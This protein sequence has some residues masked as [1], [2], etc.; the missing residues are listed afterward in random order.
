[1]ARWT[2]FHPTE[3][4]DGTRLK[5]HFYHSITPA[6]VRSVPPTA[7]TSRAA[8]RKSLGPSPERV[9]LRVECVERRV[10]SDYVREKIAYN[11]ESDLATMA[12]VCR[13][14]AKGRFP[15]V[16]CCH[17]AGPGKDP[18][19]G[20]WNGQECLE[21]HKAVSVRL[22]QRGYVTLTPDRRGF[23]ECAARPYNQKFDQYLREL[24]DF[25]LRTRGASRT[26]LD[27]WD[28]LR[29][30]DVLTQQADVDAARIGCLGV[31]DGATVAA[32]AATLDPRIR[33]ACLA[34]VTGD[35]GV[36]RLIAPRRVQLQIAKAGPPAPRDLQAKHIQRHVF[37]GVIELDFPALAEWLDA[38]L[39]LPSR[40]V[41]FGVQ[42]SACPESASPT[43]LKLE[44]QTRAKRPLTTG[45][46]VSA[47]A[48]HHR[49]ALLFR[50]RNRSD[51]QAWRRQ[52]EARFKEMLGR[53]PHRVPLRARLIERCTFPGYVREK[54]VFD[55]ERCMSV[56]AWV[57]RP[58]AKGRFPAVVCAHGHGIGGK[59]MVGLDARGRPAYDYA[60]QLAVRLAEHGFVAIAPDWRAFGERY[61]PPD[62][63]PF[64]QDL[65]NLAHLAAEHFGFNQLA[66]N[67][68]DAMR[69]IDYLAT[70]REVDAARIGCVGCSF[71][72]TMTMFLAAADRRVRAAC[73]SGYLGSTSAAL[74][75]LAT[76]G[77][78]TLPGLLRW[79]DRAEVA[80][81]ICPRPLLIQNGQFD[82]SFPW[83][84]AKPE[85]ERLQRLYRAAGHE[86][87][88]ALDLF[89]GCHEIHVP[90]VLAWFKRWLG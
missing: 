69:T 66:L 82:S 50:G 59:C 39:G 42:A 4:E 31:Y 58:R 52:F 12:W 77:S 15:A 67:V 47:M 11:V 79:G 88:L 23:G 86:S 83:S 72:G 46:W 85:Y 80:G 73:I 18:L 65:C 2:P 22:A 70:R 61:E 32:G 87:R 7:F 17:G 21:Y 54:V 38:N 55:S 10:F 9:S 13:P 53:F 1:M 75:Q 34:C 48:Q 16:L 5:R 36:L 45:D 41:S 71:G 8:F 63:D 51:H 25:Y 57:C 60:K 29:A 81:L 6:S 90:P 26:A 35:P 37:D 43:R 24:D 56:V 74:R 64:P 20:L 68:W 33:A 3:V 49:P 62:R 30:V 89:D 40:P 44:L 14:R 76:C 27:T 28:M 84:E 78:Q 19:V